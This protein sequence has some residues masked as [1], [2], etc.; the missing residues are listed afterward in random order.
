MSLLICSKYARKIKVV[1]YKQKIVL[2]GSWF[3]IFHL[4]VRDYIFAII[5]YFLI[6][7][8]NIWHVA[9]CAWACMKYLD[10]LLSLVECYSAWKQNDRLCGLVVRVPGYRSRGPG[11]ITSATRFSDKSGTGSTQPHEYNWGATWKKK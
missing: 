2:Y 4:L 10:E 8:T 1:S 5:P 11:S 9:F 6:I 3:Q 7:I